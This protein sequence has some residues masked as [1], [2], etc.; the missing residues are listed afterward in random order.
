MNHHQG[1][2]L[3]YLPAKGYGYLRLQGTREEFYFRKANLLVAEV[4][5]GDLVSFQL[6]SGRQG[7]FADQIAFSKLT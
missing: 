3:F 5:K 1:I 6:R 7:F 2:I 4:K